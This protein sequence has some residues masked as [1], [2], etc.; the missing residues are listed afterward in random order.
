MA[1][2]IDGSSPPAHQASAQTNTT[3]AFTPPDDSLLVALW[4]GDSA[5]GVVPGS[6]TLASS[7]SQTW[8][9]DAWDKLDSGTPGAVDGQ[10]LF[11]HA[12]L[13]GA[14]PGS[15]TVSIT[16]GAASAYSS[17]LKVLAMTGHDPAAPVGV[18]G[19]GRQL[20]GSSISVSFTASIS[21]GQG[22]LAVSD[23]N[24]G[25]TSGWAADTGCT[26]L[27]KAT[28]AGSISYALIQRTDPDEVVGVST[29]LG[30]TG[31][32]TGG[33]YHWA[34][35][36]VISLEAALAAGGQAGYPASGA[37]PPMF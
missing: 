4:A 1:L 33:I 20:G 10:A 6:P 11:A 3:A 36:E 12:V 25:A 21:G 28:L 32:P 23:W 2:V 13:A 15:T 37:S 29:S 18:V 27:D 8:T 31:L 22:F 17:I 7:P 14:S 34:Y 9:L 16:N 30:L 5:A 26:I 35:A 19:G 24:A